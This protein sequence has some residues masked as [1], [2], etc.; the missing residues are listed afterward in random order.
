[1]DKKQRLILLPKI[2]A[3]LNGK[4]LDHALIQSVCVYFPN[5]TSRFEV[6]T[7]LMMKRVKIF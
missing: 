7:C 2:N 6:K 1:M 3:V 5:M 4:A